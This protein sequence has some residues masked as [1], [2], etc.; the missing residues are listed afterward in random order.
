MGVTIREKTKD[1]GVW[2]VFVAHQGRRTSRKVGD[3]K[4]AREAARKIEARLT[5]GKG[6]FGE[7]A[8]LPAPTLEQYF[9]R[10]EANYKG[11]LK[12]STW[13]SYE[14]SMRIHI[15]PD[16]GN[17][18]L[19]E[20]TKPMM[21]RLVANLVEKGLARDSIRL[22]VASLGVLY[23]QAIDD[24][25]VAE[26]PTKGM[27]KFY[28]QANVKH[29]EIAP[30]TEEESLVLLEKTL[31]FEKIY[32]ALFLCA[33]HTGM[34]SG[35]LAGIQWPDI[36]WHGKFLEVHR[37][38]VRGEV[39]DLKTKNGRRKVDLSDDLLEALSNLRRQ[40]Q[41][42]AMRKGK[43]E[44]AQWVFANHCGSFADMNNVKGR[45][46]KRVLRKAGLRDIRFHDLR[47]TFASQLLC[48]G[49]NILYVSQQLGHANPQITMKI[50]SHWI[51]NDNQ[52]EVMNRLPSLSSRANSQPAEAVVGR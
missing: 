14:S 17:H 21:K 45:N 49:A 7:K 3:R 52:R 38:V 11:T 32:Y 42:E 41:E 48:N 22:I 30:L 20:I 31:E 39:T 10:F 36:D 28:R 29:E 26:N 27:G 2:W 4:A 18:R 34:R 51:P 8:K 5:L 23:T 33:L 37:Q 25:I 12:R 35:E 50:Y 44:I 6:A 16:L 46:F 24:K 15:L 19:D 13:T 43:N 47:H 9:K 1:S 40:M